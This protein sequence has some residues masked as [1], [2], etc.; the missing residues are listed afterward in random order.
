MSAQPKIFVLQRIWVEHPHIVNQLV[1]FLE[2]PGFG[3][4]TVYAEKGRLTYAEHKKQIKDE[5]EKP[6]TP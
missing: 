6:L 4:F 5:K 1:G 2:D 3:S